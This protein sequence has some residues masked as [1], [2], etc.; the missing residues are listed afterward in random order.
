M[1]VVFLLG[2]LVV[3]LV[4]SFGEVFEGFSMLARA[5]W[6]SGIGIPIVVSIL[7][8]NAFF[9]LYASHFGDVRL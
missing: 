5:T 4:V 9:T 1:Q 2:L 6:C 3:M 8:A 7:E